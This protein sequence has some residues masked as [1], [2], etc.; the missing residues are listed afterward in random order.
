MVMARKP[1]ACPVSVDL[2]S[3]AP[4]VLTNE[5]GAE[6]KE[7]EPADASLPRSIREDE[8]NVVELM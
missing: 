7:P 5:P 4:V 1:G 3:S 6:R 2:A 8:L